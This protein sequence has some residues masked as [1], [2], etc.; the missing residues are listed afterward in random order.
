MKTLCSALSAE[1]WR[2]CVLS[3]STPYFASTPEQKL[4]CKYIFHFLE[5]GSNSQPFD[6]IVTLCATPKRLASYNIQYSIMLLNKIFLYISKIFLVMKSLDPIA[7]LYNLGVYKIIKY[8]QIL[9]TLFR[10]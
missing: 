6:F 8:K 9:E 7:I 4:K 10:F 2:H 3:N 1:F 5:W